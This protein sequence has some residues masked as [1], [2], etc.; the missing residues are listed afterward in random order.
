MVSSIHQSTFQCSP[1]RSC[2]LPP[3]QILH[4]F[5]IASILT[6]LHRIENLQTKITYLDSQIKRAR[7][8]H[9][10]EFDRNVYKGYYEEEAIL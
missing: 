8:A 7:F 6:V 4:F 1:L 9:K 2:I 3:I 10:S 5:D